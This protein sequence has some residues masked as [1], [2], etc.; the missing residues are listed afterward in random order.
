MILTGKQLKL[1]CFNSPALATKLWAASKGTALG[2]LPVKNRRRVDW[3]L[4]RYQEL[5]VVE[6]HTGNQT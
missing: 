4:R 2:L 6:N 1:T 3:R 5:A